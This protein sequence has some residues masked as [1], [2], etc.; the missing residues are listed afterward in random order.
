MLVI[1]QFERDSHSSVL[2]NTETEKHH[3]PPTPW[4]TALNVNECGGTEQAVNA[5]RGTC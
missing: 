5:A 4:K 2:P 1:S 3:Q